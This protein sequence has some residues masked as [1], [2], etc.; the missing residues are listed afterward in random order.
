MLLSERLNGFVLFIKVRPVDR[1]V[2]VHF[3]EVCFSGEFRKTGVFQTQLEEFDGFFF[4]G[5]N[6]CLVSL[7]QDRRTFGK[8]GRSE[9]FDTNIPVVPDIEGPAQFFFHFSDILR[10]N[11]C[12][13]LFPEIEVLADIFPRSAE[14]VEV[15]ICDLFNSQV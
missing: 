6:S 3:F 12:C 9:K 7:F 10:G 15:F 14:T 8:V 4:S 5:G 1:G 2:V 13:A 11:M